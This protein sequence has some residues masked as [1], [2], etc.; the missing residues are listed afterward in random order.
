MENIY[1]INFTNDENGNYAVDA[2]SLHKSLGI[3]TKYA[4]WIKKH[5]QDFEEEIDYVCTSEN[6]EENHGNRKDYVLSIDMA[7][8]IAML[9]HTPIGKD[10]RNYFLQKEKEAFE[11]AKSQSKYFPVTHLDTARMLVQTL[12]EKEN[13][14]S[15][16]KTLKP[17]AEIGKG[18]ILGDDDALS[19]DDFSSIIAK[20]YGKQYKVAHQ[21]L[22]SF[23][24]KLKLVRNDYLPT[25]PTT[26]AIK[27]EYMVIS[28]TGRALITKLGRSTFIN[29]I[30][31]KIEEYNKIGDQ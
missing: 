1:N 25:Q 4:D 9:Q 23:L 12:V 26:W 3:K 6:S 15:K 31:D 17:K 7:K 29:E 5:L 19:V 21:I 28:N 13:L 30:I 24:R 10:I 22:F 16:V 8:H 2:R 20:E 18:V 27:K 14:E 11:L